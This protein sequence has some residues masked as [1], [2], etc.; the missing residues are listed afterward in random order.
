MSKVNFSVREI[1][2]ELLN[3]VN[4]L[5]KDSLMIWCREC[6]LHSLNVTKIK[7]DRCYF[8]V[9]LLNYFLDNDYDFNKD[10]V[11]FSNF[12][13]RREK[14]RA[15]KEIIRACGCMGA[16]LHNS[17]YA[18]YCANYCL[19]AILKTNLK[20]KDDLCNNEKRWQLDKLIEMQNKKVSAN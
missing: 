5:S 2:V 3:V 19:V 16:V 13:A 8:F 15:S 1:D 11:L 14:N 6:I 7:S 20:N 12:L 10:I 18:L 17:L 9:N 4:N